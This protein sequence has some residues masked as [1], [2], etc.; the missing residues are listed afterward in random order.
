MELTR[1]AVGVA[2]NAFFIVTADSVAEFFARHPLW[3]RVQR[4]VMGTALAGFA[5][6]IL[7]ERTGAAVAL[8]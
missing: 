7:T 6:K 1:T 5:V 2:G 8:R 4:H 3:Q